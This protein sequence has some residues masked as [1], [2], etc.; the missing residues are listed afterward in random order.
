[1]A[2]AEAVRKRLADAEVA[3]GSAALKVM[4]DSIRVQVQKVMI[5]SIVKANIAHGMAAARAFPQTMKGTYMT[6]P[7][8]M[9]ADFP[10]AWTNL[11]GPRRVVIT[12]PRDLRSQPQANAFGRIFVDSLR[13]ALMRRGGYAVVNQ[14]SV[15]ALLAKTRMRDEVTK[16]LHPDLL[17][18][19]QFLPGD[20]ITMLITMRDVSGTVAGP[21]VRVAT[22]KFSPTDP[23]RGIP[24]AIQMIVGNLEELRGSPRKFKMVVPGIPKPPGQ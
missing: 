19:P 6:A 9:P 20:S 5:D 23:V 11:G 8:P 14:D 22:A 12:D 21:N 2:I 7:V 4:A 10:R 18:S 1:M 24:F 15:R 16:V 3:R 13:R 17:V